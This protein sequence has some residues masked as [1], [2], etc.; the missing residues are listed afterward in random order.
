MGGAE[1][2][3]TSLSQ[4][5]LSP[6]NAAEVSKLPL[7]ALGTKPQGANPKR[8]TLSGGVSGSKSLPRMAPPSLGVAFARSI[9]IRL[10]PSFTDFS[11]FLV[12]TILSQ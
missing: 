2:P 12:Q 5:V 4:A 6:P 11:D 8:A 3:L 7:V 10:L 9:P 1:P